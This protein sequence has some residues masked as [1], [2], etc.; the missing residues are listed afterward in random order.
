LPLT[1]NEVTDLSRL[2]SIAKNIQPKHNFTTIQFP[3]NLIEIGAL[4]KL[5]EYG[6]KSLLELAKDNSLTTM[7]NR[8]LN[9]FTNNN[10]VRL[11]T[12][13]FLTKDFDEKNALSDFD[14][15][16][17][18]VYEKAKEN[19]VDLERIAL[20]KQFT[21]IWNK[22]S[23]PDSVDQ[24]YHDHFFPF[25]AQLWGDDGLTPEEAAPFYKLFDHSLLFARLEMSAK[26]REFQTQACNVGLLPLESESLFA[27][28][29]I[30]AYLD[31]GIDYVLLGMKNE[32][33]VRQVSHLFR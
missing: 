12:Y 30:E 20:V 9:A 2:I 16:M 6:D 3:F 24:V 14:F 25:L 17:N 15:A 5:G 22:L 23:S 33:Y 18:I 27:V 19:E 4:E 7:A 13:D 28:Q 1:H 21:E 32:E 31:Y 26:A 10:L 11:A 8:P 29:V